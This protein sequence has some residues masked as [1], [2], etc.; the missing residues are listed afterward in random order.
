MI[1][2]II[3]NL[4][5][6]AGNYEQAT[7]HTKKL[8]KISYIGTLCISLAEI[9]SLNWILNLYTIY[10]EVHRLTYILVVIHN[11]FAILLYPLSF[12]FPNGLRAAGDVR[13]TMMVSIG[14]MFILRIALGYTLGVVFHMGVI[15]I[16]TAMGFDW[17]IRSI[18][19]VT[20]FKGGKWMSF[21][22]I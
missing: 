12:T 1:V 21:Q 10:S 5:N 16:W 20:R 8:T 3:M 11:C 7:Y 14:S 22:V 4:A 18:A 9:A 13:Y 19:Y 17:A 15:G 6:V 2:S